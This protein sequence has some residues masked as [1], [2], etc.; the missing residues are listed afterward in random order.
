NSYKLDTNSIESWLSG[1]D[2]YVAKWYSQLPGH[3]AL[4]PHAPLEGPK[5][6][7]DGK[8]IVDEHGLPRLSFM[9]IDGLVVGSPG[10]PEPIVVDRSTVMI[11]TETDP[12]SP[13]ETF[14]AMFQLGSHIWE[15]KSYTLHG[16]SS[17][18][19]W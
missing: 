13:S 8:V 18:R 10:L 14:A 7:V 1:A 9:E 19:Y 6:A 17:H 11:V 16:R 2:G 15:N 12:S 4:V 3:P 5:I